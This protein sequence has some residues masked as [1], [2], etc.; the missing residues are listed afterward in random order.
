MVPASFDVHVGQGVWGSSEQSERSPIPAR[1][2]GPALVS[3]DFS[4]YWV[5]VVGPLAGALIA[6]GFA[7]VLRGRGGD[8]ISRAAG[9]GLLSPGSLAMR[10]RLAREIEAGRLTPPGLSEEKKGD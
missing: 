1:S 9:S 7:F 3:G 6:V 4:S 2:F 8:P 10:A 5:Y